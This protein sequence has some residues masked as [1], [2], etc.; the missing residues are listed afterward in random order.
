MDEEEVVLI[1]VLPN[2]RNSS[3]A[4]F[5]CPKVKLGSNVSKAK[6]IS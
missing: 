4:N 2:G 3:T 6:K 1:M 5:S